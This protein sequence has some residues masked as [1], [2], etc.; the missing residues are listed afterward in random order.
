[1]DLASATDQFLFYLYTQ[2]RLA[3]NTVNAYAGD[4]ARFARFIDP[5]KDACAISRTDVEAFMAFL[6]DQGLSTRS[7]AR[8]VAG[9]KGLFRFLH[10]H[11]LCQ[12]DPIADMH[13]PT[14][15]RPL[16][17]VLSQ[18][19]IEKLLAACLNDTPEGLRDRAILE[20]LYGSGLR[21]S[22]A[23]GLGMGDID[24]EE[25]ICM[26]RGKGDKQRL[27]PVG[28]QAMDALKN[29]LVHGRPQLIRGHAIIKSPG[30]RNPLFITRRGTILS[31]QG[32]FK[33]LK[34]YALAAGINPEK[35]SPHKLR[36]SFAT[37]MIEN[38]ADLRTVQTLLGHEDISTTEI[39]THVSRKHLHQA[40][41]RSHPRAKS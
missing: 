7:V 13:A 16:P 18:D 8:N 24:A 41:I 28:E 15:T 27:I 17:T 20:L 35:V 32:L 39:Y 9:I 25:G 31:R 34:K 3:K 19:E 37:H 40:F 2:R 26:V 21:I 14:F 30:T 10:E 29:Y 33:N 38:G 36:H 1:M 4:L 11:N 6:Y 23:L 5:S 12:S 22:E